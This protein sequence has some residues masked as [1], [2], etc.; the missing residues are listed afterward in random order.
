MKTHTFPQNFI[1]GAAASAYQIEG[2]W[3][4]DGKGE[5][6]WDRFSHTPGKILNGDTGDIAC[7]FYHRWP[8]DI[9][10]MKEIGLQAFRFS[11]AWTRVLPAGRG[12]IN[13]AGLDFY[14]RLVDGLL[15]AGIVPCVALYHWDLPQAL[16]EM[17]GW[18]ARSTA[19]AFAEYTDVVTRSLGDRAKYWVTF[20]EP[21]CSGLLGYQ[22]GIHAPGICDWGQSLAAIHHLLLAHGMALQVIRNNAP[23][24]Q[25][26]IVID[27]IPCQPATPAAEDYAAYRWF[28]GYHNRWFMD[29]LYGRHYPADILAEH[30]QRGNLSSSDLPFLQPGDYEIIATP[31]D[32]IGLNYYRR[33]VLSGKVDDRGGTSEPLDQPDEQHTKMGWEIYPQGL[34]ELIL[35]VYTEYRPAKIL[36]TENGASYSDGPAPDGRVHDQRRIAYLQGHI[37]AIHKAIEFGAPVE[38]YF[39]WSLLDNFEWSLGYSQRFGIVYVDYDTQLRLPKD[40]AIWYSQVIRQNGLVEP[41]SQP[42]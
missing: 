25:A 4:E 36:I 14:S 28:D 20:N 3:N 33:E 29:P 6:I 23:Q 38:G 42:A 41:E 31:T 2:G 32:F 7:D 18:P 8:E 22:M 35:N 5:S 15:E 11:I 34:L 27:P 37:Q 13:P 16:Q 39:V 12:K 21:T 17:G 10:L 9:R 1:W 24:S 19:E 40:S 30:V 26:G